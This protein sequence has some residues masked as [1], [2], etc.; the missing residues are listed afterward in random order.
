VPV[1]PPFAAL[2]VLVGEWQAA[3][4]G[5]PCRPLASF[6]SQGAAD[7]HALLRHNETSTPRGHIR[8]LCA[9]SPTPRAPCAPRTP[10]A[11][12]MRSTTSSARFRMNAGLSSNRRAQ[13]HGSASLAAPCW[14]AHWR[15]DSRSHHPTLASW[16]RT[17][18]HRP[19][20]G[21]IA[22]PGRF[23]AAWG[24]GEAPTPVIGI[25][26]I[27][28]VGAVFL[29][30]MIV[31][32]LAQLSAPAWQGRRSRWFRLAVLGVC[33]LALWVG[34]WCAFMIVTPRGHSVH[35][36]AASWRR[37]LV[38]FV[39]FVGVPAAYL[40]RCRLGRRKR[41]ARFSGGRTEGR[42]GP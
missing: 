20:P 37:S 2:P 32:S 24:T 38:G 7:G 28:L 27:V 23:R 25:L 21:G 16:R 5:V 17:L 19:S 14:T 6:S 18:K 42:D 30:G 3:G 31:R 15:R 9:F 4:A 13:G 36:L 26:P 22:S 39:A 8:T 41:P 10:T 11:K 34:W 35:P 40:I 12:G 33:S 1:P 29:V